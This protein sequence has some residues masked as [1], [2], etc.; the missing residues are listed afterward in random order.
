MATTE[1]VP[2]IRAYKLGKRRWSYNQ[3][4]LRFVQEGGSGRAEVMEAAQGATAGMTEE[5]AESGVTYQIRLD[6]GARVRVNMFIVHDE[7]RE[8]ALPPK[9]PGGTPSKRFQW[10]AVA[11]SQCKK[12]CQ[13]PVL[14]SIQR[15]G[16][17][18]RRSGN[19]PEEALES[20][21]KIKEAK[22]IYLS[23]DEAGTHVGVRCFRLVVGAYDE[24]GEV[25]LGACCSPPIRVLAN[26]DVPTGAAY[27][28]LTLPLRNDWE[29]WRGGPFKRHAGLRAISLG[30]HMDAGL[31]SPALVTGSPGGRSS[32]SGA[33][34]AGDHSSQDT[35]FAA[36]PISGA[37]GFLYGRPVG[38]AAATMPRLLLQHA[39]TC[40]LPGGAAPARADREGPNERGDPQVPGLGLGLDT[41]EPGVPRSGRL[42]SSP[43]DV[44]ATFPM[45]G[46]VQG[47]QEMQARLD[48]LATR[49]LQP[50]GVL[51][52]LAPLRLRDG[53]A[54][55]A[56]NPA[57]TL[58]LRDEGV[59]RTPPPPIEGGLC[60]RRR[61]S[62]TG[63]PQ[64]SVELMRFSSGLNPALAYPA[65]AA[66]GYAS[67]HGPHEAEDRGT[68]AQALSRHMS[69]Q[70]LAAGAPAPA[71][72]PAVDEEADE[73]QT[74]LEMAAHLC[75]VD[76]DEDEL[77]AAA[78]A[79]PPATATV[80]LGAAERAEADA[81]PWHELVGHSAFATTPNS[82]PPLWQETPP[83]LGALA[84]D[85]GACAAAPCPAPGEVT[86]KAVSVGVISIAAAAGERATATAAGAG[87]R[88]AGRVGS[89]GMGYSHP[90]NLLPEH[91][92]GTS[93]AAAP[94]GT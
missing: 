29:G 53:G 27:I 33:G 86:G 30:R 9:Q 80:S 44:L 19:V 87:G 43:E 77:A 71:P 14:R 70:A 4:E 88:D 49:Q 91:A 83:W 65:L 84:A 54:H 12:G 38:E 92:L 10:T 39:L 52:P 37:R 2:E 40:S 55:P 66:G 78:A 59:G 16:R 34:G 21:D 24:A 62:S 31:G 1:D 79:A 45:Y 64:L 90:A 67:F 82:L 75:D 60:K 23:I 69:G 42:A 56:S 63:S 13:G 47:A 3:C 35:S 41:R 36:P 6:N 32:R 73:E 26:N 7:P 58:A 89:H 46:D 74:A 5:Q 81:T 17:L 51:A 50:L 57:S 85:P 61:T 18:G 22:Y 15:Y 8:V 11:R 28:A 72:E 25:L 93:H 68:L 76:C 48:S 20:R 94:P